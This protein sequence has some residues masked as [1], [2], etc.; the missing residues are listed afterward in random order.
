MNERL[1]FPVR[2]RR[3]WLNGAVAL[4]AAALLCLSV[5]HATAQDRLVR[6]FAADQGLEVP[7]V[8]AL[9]QDRDGALWIGS[10]AG[11]Y[12]FDGVEFRRVAPDTISRGVMRLAAAADG[13]IAAQVET[14]SVFEVTRDGVTSLPQP[15]TGWPQFRRTLAYDLDGRLWSVGGDGLLIRLD[16]GGWAAVDRETF[17]GEAVVR[18]FGAPAGGLFVATDSALWQWDAPDARP[19]RWFRGYVID[20]VS[21]EGGRVVALTADIRVV[22]LD[23]DTSRV[24]ASA[25][26]GDLPQSRPISIAERVGT[27]WVAFDRH[28]IALREDRAPEWIDSLDGLDSGGPLLV[29]HEGSLWMGSFSALVQFPEPEATIW[30]ERAGLPG[31]HTRF[32]ARS[33]DVLWVTGWQGTARVRWTR[34]AP[35]IAEIAALASDSRPCADAL[36]NV[37]LATPTGVARV[38]RDSVVGRLPVKA[39]FLSCAMGAGSTLWIGTEDGL[40]RADASAGTLARV[41]DLPTGDAPVEAVLEDRSGRFW[42][43]SRGRVC[44]APTVRVRA[45]PPVASTAADAWRCEMLPDSGYATSMLETDDGTLWI[46]TRITGVLARGTNGWHTLPA[47]AR[48]ATRDV[49]GLVP[50]PADGVWI[51]GHGILHRVRPDG[52]E[53]WEILESPGPWNGLP[54]GRGADLVE[55]ED[56]TIWIATSLGLVHMPPEA[57]NRSL[58]PPR[59]LLMDARVDDEPVSLSGVLELPADRN[60]LELRFAALS[61][62]DPGRIRYQVRLSPTAPWVGTRGQPSFRWVDLPAG[63][64]QAEVRASLDGQRWSAE[65]ARFEFRV[66]PPWYRTPWAY[67][68]L[69]CAAAAVLWG[70]YRARTAYL[71]GLERQRTRI[72]MDLHDELGS[73]LGSIG[74]LASLLRVGSVDDEQRDRIADEI[75]ASARDL[76]SA[77]ADI[78]WAL[79]PRTATLEELASRLV[80]HG[81]RL[82]AGDDVDLHVVTPAQWPTTELPLAIRREVLL[83]GLEAL[84]NAARHARARNVTLA[85]RHRVGVWELEVCDDGVGLDPD[86][87]HPS[88]RGRG[89]RGMQ[90]RAAEIG[91]S[92]E[93]LPNPGGGTCVRLRFS[94]SSRLRRR[95][96][97]SPAGRAGG[98]PGEG[99][100]ESGS[101]PAVPAGGDGGGGTSEAR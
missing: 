66:L 83:I 101:R 58:E 89:L 54:A 94:G 48:L 73:G 21:G 52:P 91:A 72:A 22:E 76:G 93:W 18:V 56:G 39:S 74:I 25:A 87:F 90:R 60:R 51:L 70:V 36:G 47:N 10:Q 65:P 19:R 44:N 88:R 38:R 43:A 3:I 86:A 63:H 85:W 2:R 13:R 97:E 80:E 32:L 64:Y 37:W 53:G 12:R 100:G 41:A 26:A 9:V 69:A 33:A 24:L 17:D 55:D 35:E 67:G 92:I 84:H 98:Q 81:E 27:L 71:L 61:Y 7:P 59:V 11:L 20:L 28:L 40:L 49:F 78:V 4:R 34:S 95:R 31:R 82:F 30:Y 75:A 77:L 42:I 45:N 14:G 5:S 6:R 79:D 1:A 23:R 15:A 29:D 16:E 99:H 62:R 57:R 96:P 8:H 68:L 50:S 46:S